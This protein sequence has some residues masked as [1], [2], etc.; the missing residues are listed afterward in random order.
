LPT[1]FSQTTSALARDR[2][3]AGVVAW[4]IGLILL[5][6]WLSWFLL[7]Q[8]TV[9]ETSRRA[10]LEVTQLPHHVGAPAAGRITSVAVVIGQEVVPG[11]VLFT[12]DATDQRLG[13]AEAEARLAGL[14]PRIASIRQEIVALQQARQDE[15]RASQSAIEAARGRVREGEA[16]ARFA[17]SHEQKMR[18]Q[19]KAGGVA[20][21]DAL[22]AK[23]E[24]D[25]L[26]AAR[27]AL[28]ADLRRFEQDRQQRARE[29]EARIENLGRTATALQGEASALQAGIARM[30]AQIARLSVTSPVAGKVGDLA[31][32]TAGAYVQDGQRLASVV[33]PGRLTIIGEFAPGSATGRVHPGQAAIMRLEG[34]PWAQYGSIAATVTRVASELRDGGLRVEL[35]PA[36]T[37]NPDA[38]MQH[39]APGHVEVAVERTT[40]ATLVLRA[41]GLLLSAPL[42]ANAAEPGR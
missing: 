6:A 27:D 24:A 35:T 32:L 13:L 7:G 17:A 39:G 34:F 16:A 31:A 30:S 36:T 21:I 23:A 11:E 2:S 29:A 18:Q 15:Q 40:P 8:V 10:R 28:A 41:A 4:G 33:P 3:N 9:Y 42:R 19:A 20:E 26:A 12:L 1:P 22:R 25:K 14:P 38:I 5:G 37:G